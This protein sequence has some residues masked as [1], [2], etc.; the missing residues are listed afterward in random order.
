MIGVSEYFHIKG[1]WQMCNVTVSF[2]S[3]LKVLRQVNQKAI[4]KLV[5]LRDER[6]RGLEINKITHTGDA[7][8]MT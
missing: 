3:F 4:M 7:G 6:G 1:L 8:L 5:K 2:Q